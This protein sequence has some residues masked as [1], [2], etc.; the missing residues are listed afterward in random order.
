MVSTYCQHGSGVPAQ[1]V[2]FDL[3]VAW[4]WRSWSPCPLGLEASCPARGMCSPMLCQDLCVIGTQI[5][6]WAFPGRTARK[7][8]HIRYHRDHRKPRI[9]LLRYQRLGSQCEHLPI[10]ISKVDTL[11]FLPPIWNLKQDEDR[12]IFK[13]YSPM[14]WEHTRPFQTIRLLVNIIT[15]SENQNGWLWLNFFDEARISFDKHLTKQ[16]HRR[17]KG[18][19]ACV[20]QIPIFHF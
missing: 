12:G 13:T 5:V 3:D 8:S 11:N 17:R 6:L 9:D 4:K 16:C 19:P 7:I 18:H 2:M 15:I 20:P 10:N 1:S 14:N